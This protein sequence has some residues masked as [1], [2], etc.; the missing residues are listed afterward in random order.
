MNDPILEFNP[1]L[2]K[3]SANEKKVLKL[4]VEAGKLIAPIYLEQEKQ[5]LF[6]KEEIEKAAKK[7]PQILSPYTALEKVDGK[8][9][10]ISYHKK[11]A[12]LLKPVAEKL[13]EVARITENKEF[14]KALKIQTKAL[15]EG[16]YEEAIATWLKLKPYILDI[17]IGPINHI[18]DKFF[19]GKASYQAW[20]GVLDMEGT[21]RLNNYKNVIVNANRKA[22][23]PKE[24]IEN[25]RPVKAKTIDEVLLAGVLARTKF[26][27]L[28]LPMDSQLATKYGLEVTIFN[29]MNDL[30][31]EE[32]IMPTFHKI[33][34]SGFREGFSR[35]DLRRGSMHYVALHELAHNYLHY[36]NSQD[37]LKDLFSPIFEL[38]ATVLG[39]RMVGALLLKDIITNKQLESMIVA[40]ICRS[41]NLMEKNEELKPLVNYTLGGIIFINYMIT[42]GALKQ[43]KKMAIP[44]FMKIF[45]SL[46]ELSY[47]LERLLASGTRKDAEA[48]INK[49]AIRITF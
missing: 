17:S 16:T 21:K 1:K 12:A 14:A 31:V 23:L 29:Q 46:Q 32:Q 7:N 4:L 45:V 35:E 3:L 34:S 37:N 40:F 19:F 38:E 44:N 48:F 30:R 28:N 6:S 47:I 33:F 10:A 25:L 18:D 20:V 27:G 26:V 41:F 5:P 49:Y 9:V 11:Y 22:L 2:P 43:M 39:L 15:I 8:L 24:R 13:N 36:K 42:N